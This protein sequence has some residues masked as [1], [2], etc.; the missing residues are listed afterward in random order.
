M[1][2]VYVGLLMLVNARRMLST[3]DFC[4]RGMRAPPCFV[5]SPECLSKFMA[6]YHT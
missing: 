3:Y 4:A 1:Y 2:Y 6:T 5:L